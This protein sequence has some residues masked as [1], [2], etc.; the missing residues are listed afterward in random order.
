MPIAALSPA[1]RPVEAGDERFEVFEVGAGVEE[2]V[3]K[4]VVE[5]VVESV[6]DA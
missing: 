2:L 3:L 6:D 1:E 4:L 5:S